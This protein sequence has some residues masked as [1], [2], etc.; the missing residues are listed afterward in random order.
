MSIY[1][2]V[3]VILTALILVEVAA[4]FYLLTSR[5]NAQTELVLV[6]G[7][8]VSVPNLDV[9]VKLVENQIPEKDCN[10]CITTTKLIITVEGVAKTLEYTCGGFSGECTTSQSVNGLKVDLLS[11][12]GKDE[13]KIGVKKE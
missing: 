4:I 11:N 10:D 7:E 1:S 12:Y 9:R 2:K 5:K 6:R 13:V 8:E 3:A